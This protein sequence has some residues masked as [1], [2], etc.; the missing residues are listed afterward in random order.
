MVI[1]LFIASPPFASEY[2]T[3][4]IYSQAVEARN[5]T[6]VIENLQFTETMRSI[7]DLWLAMCSTFIYSLVLKKQEGSPGT[8]DQQV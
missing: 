4:V 2:I 3:T 8:Y 6:E 7:F 5:I 1:S